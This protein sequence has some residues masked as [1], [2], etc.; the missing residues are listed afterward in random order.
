MGY[1]ASSGLGRRVTTR[2]YEADVFPLRA[3]RGPIQF[4]FNAGFLTPLR[5]CGR[6]LILVR[7]LHGATTWGVLT[8][9]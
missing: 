7:L 5:H 2:R 3:P 8:L 9:G 1:G 6:W 4:K